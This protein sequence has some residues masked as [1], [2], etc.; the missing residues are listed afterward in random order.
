MRVPL[1]PLQLR[2]GR[3]VS[4]RP[5]DRGTQPLACARLPPA[6]SSLC[7]AA[8]SWLAALLTGRL[9]SLIPFSASVPR[10]R[11]GEHRVNSGDWARPSPAHSAG[12]WTRGVLRKGALSPDALGPLDGP[13]LP[14]T[15][16]PACTGGNPSAGRIYQHELLSGRAQHAGAPRSSACQSPQIAAHRRRPCAVV[17]FPLAEA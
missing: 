5:Q 17:G 12:A 1:V 2:K 14:N 11:G 15:A 13:L 3:Q 6:A 10:N 4:G 7:L 9:S 8:L 16:S